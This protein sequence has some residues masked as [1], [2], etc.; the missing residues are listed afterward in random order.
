MSLA[1]DVEHVV[2][3]LLGDGWH[4]VVDDSFDID[5]YD[6]VSTMFLDQQRR[7]DLVDGVILHEAGAGGTC[8]VGF[9]FLGWDGY[10]VAGPLTAV[11]AVRYGPPV[12]VEGIEEEP[13]E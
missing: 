5:A 2:S 11:L 4:D 8:P 1:I 10:R 6:F 13:D 3:V 9:S 7:G 12:E